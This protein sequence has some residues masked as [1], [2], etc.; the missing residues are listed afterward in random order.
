MGLVQHQYLSDHLL[1]KRPPVQVTA[2]CNMQH[3]TS[4]W[5]LTCIVVV[6]MCKLR[7]CCIPLQLAPML[8]LA[9]VW[10]VRMSVSYLCACPCMWTSVRTLC[11]CWECTS[12]RSLSMCVP[13]VYI[14]HC[15]FPLCMSTSLCVS[16]FTALCPSQCT[17]V[18]VCM[19]VFLYESPSLHLHCAYA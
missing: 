1:E 9:L 16:E 14:C 2:T 5:A 7:C 18:C 10:R 13:C 19:L 17:S 3:A 4:T 11:A 8:Q 12:V 15:A 6:P